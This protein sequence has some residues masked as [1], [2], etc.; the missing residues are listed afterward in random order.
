MELYGAK[1]ETWKEQEI[2]QLERQAVRALQLRSPGM[3]H[4]LARLMLP[5]VADPRFKIHL[6]DIE[7]WAREVRATA[8][9][10]ERQVLGRR[11]VPQD[12]LAHREI[13]AI[14]YKIQG[15]ETEQLIAQ[16][17]PIGAQA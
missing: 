8:Y 6:A 13:M 14:W 12:A 4:E 2:L 5:E 3:P 7:R 11:R 1:H 9:R 17:G 16:G 15:A 10:N